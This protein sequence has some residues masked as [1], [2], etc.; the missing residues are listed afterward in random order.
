MDKF[1]KMMKTF[2]DYV[3]ECFKGSFLSGMTYVLASMILMMLVVKEDAVYSE[4]ITWCVVVIVLAAAYNGLV[5]WNYGGMNFEMLVSGNM[6]RIS[7]SQYGG[8]YKISSHKLVKEYRPWKGFVYGVFMS[9]FAIVFGLIFGAN[10]EAINGSFT[11]ETPDRML[12]VLVLVGLFLSGWSLLPF[13]CMSMAGMTA[14]YYFSLLFAVL[15][16]AVSGACYIWGAYAKRAKSLRAQELA[17]K[18]AAAQANKPK[19][20]N[21][22]G[23][24]GTKPRKKK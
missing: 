2:W 6:K 15:P 22:G 1:K 4:Q 14:S 11:G 12:G 13:Y 20:I 10:Q 3:W 5:V 19:K 18:A 21:Y 17:D 9:V 7:A 8:E 23:L 16:I 24:P